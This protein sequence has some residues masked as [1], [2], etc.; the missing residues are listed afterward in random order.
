MRTL[1]QADIE[2]IKRL[3][4]SRRWSIDELAVLFG[5]THYQIREAITISDEKD[6]AIAEDMHDDVRKGIER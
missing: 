3:R 1:E 6:E 5:V 2:E 4:V